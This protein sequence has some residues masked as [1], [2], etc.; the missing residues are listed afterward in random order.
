MT[1]LAKTEERQKVSDSL[2]EFQN[3]Q[4]SF[5]PKSRITAKS[6]PTPKDMKDVLLPKYQAYLHLL[7]EQW[8]G[9]LDCAAT[10]YKHKFSNQVMI[11]GQ[12]P[13]ATSVADEKTWNKVGR[14]L[15][16]N[17]QPIISIAQKKSIIV[18]HELYDIS[19]TQ[20]VEVDFFD[21][22]ISDSQKVRLGSALSDL[23]LLQET[24]LSNGL[25][26][27]TK[28][29][30]STCQTAL[31]KEAANAIAQSATYILCKKLDLPYTNDFANISTIK[32]ENAIIEIGEV[33]QSTAKNM[34]DTIT[35]QITKIRSVDN[36]Q[37]YNIRRPGIP[38]S[39]GE[40]IF[41]QQWDNVR[42]GVIR[43]GDTN[44]QT[45]LANSSQRGQLSFGDVR[46]EIET[47][48]GGKLRESF[49]EI[50]DGRNADEAAAS[51]G[52]AAD[53][54][55]NINDG[56]DGEET[57][58]SK[59]EQ[60]SGGG[61]AHVMDTGASRGTSFSGTLPTDLAANFSLKQI[62]NMPDKFS[63]KG[64]FTDN[65]TAI[66]LLKEIEKQ[67]RPAT[68]DEQNLLARYV[69]WGG[70]ANAFDA[71]NTSWV[72]EYTALKTLLTPQEYEKAI[73]STLTAYYTDHAVIEAMYK[74][75]INLGVSENATLLE[76]SMGVGN[77]F[78]MLP[79][80]LE[81]MQLHGVELDDL[82]GRIAKQLYPNAKIQ[83]KGYQD[84]SYLDNL[85]D[86]C[87]GNVPF[88]EFKISDK[89]H[90]LLIHDYFFAKSID[91]VKPN[92]IVAFITSKGTLDKANPSFR[93]YLAQRAELIGAVRLP[94]TAFKAVAGTE[95]TTDIIFLRKREQ[96]IVD[97]PNW[98][99]T[100]LTDDNITV[101]Q[102]YIDNPQNLLGTMVE[103]SSRFGT[104]TALKPLN[105]VELYPALNTAI[106]GFTIGNA[107]QIQSVLS[108]IST[109]DE[110]LPAD[111]NV[112]NFTYTVVDDNLYYR[113]ND[114]MNLYDGKQ[115]ERVKS[116]HNIRQTV[117][118]IIFMQGASYDE[119]EFK[120]QLET[121]NFKYDSFVKTHG[122]INDKVNKR[123]FSDDADYP[124]LLSIEDVA[125]NGDITKSR[126]FSEATIKPKTAFIPTT[127]EDLITLSMSQLGDIN[128]TFMAEQFNVSTQDVVENLKGKIFLNPQKQNYETADQYLSGNV[129]SK[130]NFAQEKSIEEPELYGENVHALEQVQP[131]L[132]TADD[133]DMRLGSNFIDLKYYKQFIYEFAETPFYLMQ[134]DDSQP[135]DR[136][137]L[138]Y[139]EFTSEYTMY[140]KGAHSN[141][142][143]NSAYGT[144]RKPFYYIV[145]DTLNL[146]DVKVYDRIYVDDKEKSV[147]NIK[148][149]QIARQKQEIIRHEFK[150]W[151]L[152]D[153]VRANDVIATYN[154]RFNV[155]RPQE[156]NGKNLFFDGMSN[157]ITLREHQKNAVARC[158]YGGTNV[159]LGHVVG[160]GKT[161]TMAAAAMELKRIGIA[162]KPLFVVP[163][164]LTEQW[165]SDFLKL[166]PNANILVA[167]KK[168]FEPLNRKRFIGRICTGEYD[169][170]IIGHTQFER[171]P[172]SPE[173]VKS[174]LKEQLDQIIS[175]ISQVSN[176]KDTKRYTI[177]QLELQKAK[178]TERISNLKMGKKDNVI[179]FEETG[180]DYLF[181][182]EAHSYKN[183]FVFTKMSNVA[184]VTTTNAQKSF[185]MLM[186]TRFISAKNYG[187]GVIFATGTPISNSMT[188]LFVMQRYLQPNVLKNARIANFDEWASTFGETQTALELKPEGTGYRLRTRFA[189]FH[190]LPELVNMF[191]LVA[192]IKVAAD[193]DLPTPS[194]VTGKPIIEVSPASEFVRAYIDKLAMRAEAIRDG[195]VEPWEDNMLKITGEGKAVALDARLI[196]PNAE[197]DRDSKVYKCCDNVFEIYNKFEDKRALQ[198]IF[199]DTGLSLY[200]IIRDELVTMGVKENEIAFIHDPKTDEQKAQL[201][202]KCRSGDIRVLL[203][204]TQKMG[205]G[206]NVQERLVANHHL[207]CP[208]KPSCIEQRDG[209]MLR[210]GNSFDDVYIYRYITES[211]F[212]GYLWG[213]QEN[214]Q[215]FITQVMTNKSAVRSCDDI[216]S[217]VLDCAEVK[218][219]ATGDPRIKQKMQ[220]DN[221]VYLL[222]IERSAY[223]KERVKLQ[224]IVA[225]TP[226]KIE[227]LE[228]KIIAVTKDFELIQQRKGVDF[229]IKIG[230]ITFDERAKA[231]ERLNKILK[232]SPPVGSVIGEYCGF[233]LVTVKSSFFESTQLMIKSS[234]EY[235][236]SLG[237]S[238]VGNITRIEN[239]CQEFSSM[240]SSAKS[241]IVDLTHQQSDATEELKKPFIKEDVLK[242]KLLAQV[243]LN[244]EMEFERGVGVVMSDD[245]ESIARGSIEDELER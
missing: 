29:V 42:T 182:D 195:K 22:A 141:I 237:Q 25:V 45:T 9:F 97:E 48:H 240:I 65:V 140:N 159:L 149:T 49:V 92:G 201:F 103:Q 41:T 164:H 236:I 10:V 123:A 23:F 204:S 135:K 63:P 90:S 71:Q 40:S 216:D 161:Y 208:W 200:T 118:D 162:R 94:D 144:D 169:A 210:Q 181:V 168:D 57:S 96:E 82:T 24:N 193:L 85:F 111:P 12:Y 215:K 238:D 102:Y 3:E 223:L 139:N 13:T 53:R 6:A 158:L 46:Q 58:T 167:K 226:T 86:V 152:R 117:R 83:I 134:K 74:G 54:Y 136:I 60:Y 188:E 151:L 232:E 171:I 67:D 109:T 72:D 243:A 50:N 242:E 170:I 99:Y 35:Q 59:D 148:E 217:A 26:K 84:T 51:K 17:Q 137:I 7:P 39:G 62:E 213:I 172:M 239:G 175:T 113:E 61:T 8:T 112:K 205:A 76:P 119:L 203:G 186:K 11:Y 38:S 155:F 127:Y 33:L 47:V 19:Q 115:A 224:D 163:N 55:E 66:T 154:D 107:V 196:N 64:K 101:N 69:G 30:L 156:F 222:Q 4:L 187:T 15:K 244:S 130:L 218:T 145:E 77:F 198:L 190:N 36:E 173:F 52:T 174:E 185:D 220:L 234:Y 129:K 2:T 91:K 1:R 87:I 21:F 28:G 81:K 95:V 79:K 219:L 43:D 132:L 199:L 125:G 93:K 44:S 221:D 212:D 88:G 126:M 116:L 133:I 98:V 142:K 70:L 206:T 227:A 157:E 110:V 105:G 183:C 231:G 78:A 176:D 20:G 56:R 166:Y 177:K 202:A 179:S 209:R 37:N 146:K 108:P 89:K 73:A 120:S 114:T 121:L 5:L 233:D 31:E 207:D 104:T 211:T 180:I 153:P 225:T 122:Y 235:R 34:L 241:G 150:D 160:S 16:F 194:L 80:E 165:G 27:L 18:E 192:D 14:Q 229:K 128:L 124:L 138:T 245:S 197:V 100:G 189:K 230:D 143:T 147:L 106:H 75:I 32:D 68:A 178:I 184:G 228:Q 191:S 131:T 214:K